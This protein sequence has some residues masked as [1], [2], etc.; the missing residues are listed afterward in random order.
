MNPLLRPRHFRSHPEVYAQQLHHL[1]D[2]NP[3]P[4]FRRKLSASSWQQLCSSYALPLFVAAAALTGLDGAGLR[5]LLFL[6]GT[7]NTHRLTA[8]WLAADRQWRI[9]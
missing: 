4:P 7:Q 9:H 8:N 2:N 1:D 3:T 6:P 5:G